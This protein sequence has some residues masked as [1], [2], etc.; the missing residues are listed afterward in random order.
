MTPSHN[1]TERFLTSLG[2]IIAP[3]KIR[4]E[5]LLKEHLSAGEFGAVQELSEASHYALS[6]SGKRFR[7]AI[8]WMVGEALGRAKHEH[9]D[10]AAFAVEYFHT[11]SL[12][13][14]DL[15]CMDNDDMR[16]GVLTTHK[17]FSE[18]TA[19]LASFSLIALGFQSIARSKL[20]DKAHP[21]A[22]K[23]A[24][25]E[26]SRTMGA[27]GLIGGQLVD[28]NPP[29]MS[30]KTIETII[31]MKTGALFEL[32]FTL[33]WIFGGGDI[34][35]LQHV[36][37]LALHF[38]RAFQI[39]DDIDDIEKD[40]LSGKTVNYALHFGV[41]R[42]IKAVDIHVRDAVD[43]MENRL[44]LYQECDEKEKSL[45]HMTRLLSQHAHALSLSRGE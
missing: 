3:H 5:E 39:L 2:M 10:N 9:L 31:D 14:D 24:I 42:A 32:S 21:D 11:S 43:L 38:G 37:Q 13:A 12:I 7:P 20:C 18:A 17:A 36:R 34:A 16:R 8:V 35:L 45:I 27:S 26:S 25:L 41:N 23:R 29:D 30:Q 15:P 4:F 40:R 6:S 33:G 19:I 44:K 28:L 1:S 22:V